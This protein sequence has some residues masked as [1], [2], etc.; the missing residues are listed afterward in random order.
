M[1]MQEDNDTHNESQ[2]EQ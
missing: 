1:T 2:S